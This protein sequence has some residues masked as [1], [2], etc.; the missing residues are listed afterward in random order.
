MCAS[1]AKVIDTWLLCLY[2][3]VIQA[4]QSLEFIQLENSYQASGDE[5]DTDTSCMKQTTCEFTILCKATK[6]AF[7]QVNPRP[8]NPKLW[9]FYDK[10]KK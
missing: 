3:S 9:S 4:D 2:I 6:F 1:R 5:Q 8:K 10:I 7:T